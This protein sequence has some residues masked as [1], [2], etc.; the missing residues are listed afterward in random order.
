MEVGTPS[1]GVLHLEGVLHY[2]RRTENKAEIVCKDIP[3]NESRY[4]IMAYD[5]QMSVVRV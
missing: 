3:K 5:G 2:I 1:G 4:I